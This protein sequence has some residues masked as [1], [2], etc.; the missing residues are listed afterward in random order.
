MIPKALS[1]RSQRLRESDK[2]LQA[3]YRAILE[4]IERLKAHIS[5]KTKASEKREYLLSAGFFPVRVMPQLSIF[6]AVSTS[7]SLRRIWNHCTTAP[8]LLYLYI[9][10]YLNSGA[11]GGAVKVQ[12][13]AVKVQLYPLVQCGAP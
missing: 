1:G 12:C 9:N 8:F 3:V 7:E 6:L 10:Y 2:A 5:I 11:D 4:G 13:G